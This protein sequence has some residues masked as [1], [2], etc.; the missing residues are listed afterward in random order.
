MLMLRHCEPK[1]GSVGQD[2][3]WSDPESSI[4]GFLISPR[5]AGYLFGR[6]VFS[7]FLKRNKLKALVRSHQLCLEGYRVV[8]NFRNQKYVIWKILICV[9]VKLI[10]YSQILFYCRIWEM[11]CKYLKYLWLCTFC[12]FVTFPI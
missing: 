6:K 4:E 9:Y 8:A 12:K 10:F 1:D 11:E 2:I 5:G 7:A 3:L